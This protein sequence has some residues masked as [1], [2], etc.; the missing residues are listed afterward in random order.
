MVTSAVPD[1]PSA[2]YYTALGWRLSK[3]L[4]V[5]PVLLQ[6]Q[7]LTYIY[8]IVRLVVYVS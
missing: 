2:V 3:Q 7:A 5:Y 1:I 4:R 6:N 8:G